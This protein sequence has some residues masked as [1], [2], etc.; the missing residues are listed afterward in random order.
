MHGVIARKTVPELL[1]CEVLQKERHV[2]TL[3]FTLPLPYNCTK[4]I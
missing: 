2:N 3:T 1:E 4:P